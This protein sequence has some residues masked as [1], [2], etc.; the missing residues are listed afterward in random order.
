MRISS[1]SS[2]V[3]HGGC[4][5]RDVSVGPWCFGSASRTSLVQRVPTPFGIRLRQTQEVLAVVRSLFAAAQPAIDDRGLTLIGIAIANLGADLPRQLSLPLGTEDGAV[6]DGALDEIRDRFG[7]AAITR[8]V[9]LGRSSGLTMP[10]LPGDDAPD[11]P[12]ADG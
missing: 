8:A 4:G 7:T 3:S 12:S 6:L 11:E 2:I 10:L 1:R 5:H 9:L